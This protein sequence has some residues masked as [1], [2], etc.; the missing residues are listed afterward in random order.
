MEWGILIVGIIVVFVVLICLFLKNKQK[1]SE[2]QYGLD[3]NGYREYVYKT[4][5][6]DFRPYLQQILES[7]DTINSIRSR[8]NSE[9]NHAN[10]NAMV[11]IYN[12]ANEIEKKIGE[13]WNSK[14]FNKDFS[15]YIGLHYASHLLG[16][17]IKQEQ[18]VIKN[19]FVECKRN[20]NQWSEKIVYLKYRQQRVSGKQKT[21]ISQEIASCCKIH[22]QI[23][24]LAS[25]IGATNTKYNQRVSQQHMETAKRRDYIAANFGDRGKSWKERMRKRAM[26]RKRMRGDSLCYFF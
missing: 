25:Q 12:K 13:Y 10:Y 7:I 4:V 8:H 23:S 3:D 22:K 16:N 5:Q 9:L 19:T 11:D 17:A 14:Q 24:V 15:Y 6:K 21:E 2:Y 18:Q 26:L 20:Q 1:N